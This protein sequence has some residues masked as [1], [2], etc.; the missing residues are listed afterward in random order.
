[1]GHEMWLVP[2]DY[3]RRGG[4]KNHRIGMLLWAAGNEKKSWSNTMSDKRTISA[5]KQGMGIYRCL[6]P[7][8]KN[9]CDAVEC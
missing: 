3:V 8:F 2:T 5:R 7:C 4:Q 9:A 6:V 1:M